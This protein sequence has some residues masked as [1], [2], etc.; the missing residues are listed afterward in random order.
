[1]GHTSL[2]ELNILRSMVVH[3]SA[4]SDISLDSVKS[5]AFW[6]QPERHEIVE[7]GIIVGGDKKLEIYSGLQN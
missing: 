4:S 2:I 7:M 1:M 6:S 3:S 5:L